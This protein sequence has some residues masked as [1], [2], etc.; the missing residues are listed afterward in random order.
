MLTRLCCTAALVT[1]ICLF[2]I[3]SCSQKTPKT[4]P[5]IDVIGAF[6]RTRTLL[7]TDIVESVEYVKLET[8]PECLLGEGI[9]VKI[10]DRLYIH[11]AKTKQILV[12]DRSGK[13]IGPIGSQGQGPGEY[14]NFAHF[15][16]SQDGRLL[17]L[18][19]FGEIYF[20]STE[21]KFLR[22]TGMADVFPF[23]S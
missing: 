10:A 4:L 11:N 15:D 14:L 12:F 19:G 17:A 13:F 21:G 18:G 1:G 2:S 7:L 5:V 22:R 9:S 8:T 20:Y 16:V 23:L 6:D 3:S